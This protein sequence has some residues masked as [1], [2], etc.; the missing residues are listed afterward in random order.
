M[1]LDTPVHALDRRGPRIRAIVEGGELEADRV[2]LA[3]PL[4]LLHR[5]PIDPV[6]P[7]WKPEPLGRVEIGQAAKLRIPLAAPAAT[8]A[9]MSVPGRFWCWTATAAD[10]SVAP[11]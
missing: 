5:L 9:V 2:V 3:V 4:P 6:L 10:G 7:E 8:S 1:K 11:F